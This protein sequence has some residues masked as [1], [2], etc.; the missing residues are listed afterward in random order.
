MVLDA[1]E[2]ELVTKNDFAI[3]QERLD[4]RFSRI[5]GRFIQ[6]DKA[7]IESTEEERSLFFSNCARVVRC[8]GVNHSQRSCH[9]L[10]FV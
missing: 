1:V 4:T 10:N 2:G 8:W 6:I 5:D 3:F 7:Q 9:L